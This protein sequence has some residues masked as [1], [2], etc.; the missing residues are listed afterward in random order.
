MEWYQLFKSYILD[1]GIE[2]YENGYVTEF[3]Y[4]D[5]V[6]SAVV[7]GTEEYHIDI[8]VDGEDVM[9]MSCDCPHARS[10]NNC[11]HMAAVLFKYEELLEK[12][13][14]EIDNKIE[15]ESFGQENQLLKSKENIQELIAKIPYERQQDLLRQYIMENTALRNCLELEYAEEMDAQQMLA[16]KM[17]IQ[18]LVRENSIHGFID[19]NHAYDFCFDLRNFL[20]TKVD[21]LLERKWLNQAFELVNLVFY[22]IGTIDIDDSDGGTSMVAEKCYEYWKK[23]LDKCNV[24]QKQKMEEWFKKHETGYV[25]DI[26]DEYIKEFLQNE[27]PS[28]ERLCEMMQQL[29]S[30]IVRYGDR[31]DSPY[32]Y[33][34]S[35]GSEDAV[36]KRIECMKKLQYPDSEIKAYRKKHR[37]FWCIRE[38]EIQEASA[39][40][41]MGQVEKLLK[42]SLEIDAAYPGQQLEYHEQLIQLYRNNQD[43]TAYKAELIAYLQNRYAD[44]LNYYFELKQIVETESEWNDIIDKIVDIREKTEFTCQILKEEHRYAELMDLIEQK[45]DIFLLERYEKPLKKEVPERVIA[46]YKEYLIRMADIASDRKKY[47]HLMPYLKKIASCKNGKVIANQIA[48]EW[49]EK[50]KRRTAMM[51]E[52]RKAGY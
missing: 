20:D 19:W 30:L 45:N 44:N 47:R 40:G 11:K 26:Y 36:L 48:E 27:F 9:N 51:D 28:E 3:S 38:L 6:I 33:S 50:Y 22:N 37:H 13:D 41:D 25:I 5:G 2:Y 39:K 52:L 29:D 8:E 24:D 7:D 12:E 23:I 46:L 21:L 34:V 35:A 1:R 15:N 43:R 42:E 14:T 4:E 49:H 10:G 17:E 31:N 32:W 18:D 16:L